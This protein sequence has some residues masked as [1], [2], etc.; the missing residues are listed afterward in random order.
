M[1]LEQIPL[2]KHVMKAAF[3]KFDEDSS[4][5]ITAG[6]LDLMLKDN[7]LQKS[8][9]GYLFGYADANKDGEISYS[10]FEQ[11]ICE[12]PSFEIQTQLSTISEGSGHTE[13]CETP[14]SFQHP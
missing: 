6:N 7:N 9:L 2:R 12:P 1:I 5:S 11:C 13:S 3:K 4:G 14:G 10:E 8:D